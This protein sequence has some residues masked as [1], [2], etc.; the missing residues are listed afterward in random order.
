MKSDAVRLR[1]SVGLMLVAAICLAGITRG[2]MANNISIDTRLSQLGAYVG[3]T[4]QY[5]VR[6]SRKVALRD[7]Q[8]GWPSAPNHARLAPL[9]VREDTTMLRDGEHYQVSEWRLR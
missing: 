4:V 8:M 5:I 1:T 7:L 2:G 3:E 9:G 6:L